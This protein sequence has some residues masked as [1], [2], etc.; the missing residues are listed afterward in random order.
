[1]GKFETNQIDLNNDGKIILYQRP[2]VSTKAKWQC[3]IS[4]AGSTGYKIFS[5]KETNQRDAERVA[6]DRYEELYFKVKRGGALKGKPFNEVV[7]EYANSVGEL[8]KR[9]YKENIRRLELLAVPFFNTKPVDEIT[10]SDLKDMMNTL[11]ISLSTSTFLHYRNSMMLIFKFAK[12]KGYIE[13]IHPI[14]APSLIR[15]PR[16]D[17]PVKE[18]KN[19]TTYMRKWVDAEINQQQG[20]SYK[21]PR[22]HRERFYLQHYVLIMGNTG[23]R[24]GEM[25]GVRWMD[26]DSVEASAGDER[27]LFAVDGKTGKRSVVANAGVENYIRRIWEFRTKELG[28]EPNKQEHIFCH[29]NGKSVGSYKKGY[30]YLLNECDL[31]K[32]PDGMNR[33]LYSLRHTY[34]T[35]RINEVSVY[36]LAVNMGTSVEMIENYYSHART[37]DPVFVSAIT[38][39]NQKTT[40]KALPF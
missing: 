18:W 12:T 33:T 25:R 21:S 38:K 32:A 22:I 20:K 34:A 1:M 35:M 23:I 37:S 8:P 13:A 10:E 28:F 15:N 31:R 39:G 16:P 24:I 40:G 6:R 7:K 9:Y 3:R 17:F 36:Q 5:T 26:L 29:T 14:E 27:L 19:L 2:D 30:E 4:V 11:D